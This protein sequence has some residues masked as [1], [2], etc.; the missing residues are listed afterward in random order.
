MPAR[1]APKLIRTGRR[2]V[3]PV[4]G[5]GPLANRRQPLSARARS[6]ARGVRSS[7]PQ[8]T[9]RIP[10]AATSA[11]ASSGMAAPSIARGGQPHERRPGHRV[12]LAHEL[13]ASLPSRAS[14]PIPRPLGSSLRSS[15]WL[16]SQPAFCSG[17]PHVAVV[18]AAPPPPARQRRLLEGPEVGELRPVVG[19]DG[20][21]EPP[22]RPAAQGV[23]Q[24]AQG[25]RDGRLRLLGQKQRQL[26]LGGPVA[27]RGQTLRVAGE[28]YD[29]VRSRR[30]PRARRRAGTETPRTS[31]P[32]RAGWA[33]ARRG[34]SS[35]CSRPC[36]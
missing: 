16:R 5:L 20:P 12:E 13:G 36:A 26:G 22:E 2:K 21:E 29:A 7:S 15:T 23:L 6:K 35:A 33:W 27:G 24:H 34:P 28:P 9:S 4:V 1:T 19:Q 11:P 25:A 31:A 10:S 30:P 8:G 3:Y 18:D 14:K 17:L 32:A